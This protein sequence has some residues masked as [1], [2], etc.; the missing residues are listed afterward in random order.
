MLYQEQSEG[1]YL[2]STHL[3]S[4]RR[5]TSLYRSS[6]AFGRYRI[7]IERSRIEWK[8]ML[9]WVSFLSRNSL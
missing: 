8:E 9:V 2:Y 3:T 6:G 7:N 4:G 5:S 1:E